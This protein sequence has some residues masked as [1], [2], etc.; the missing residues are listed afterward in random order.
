MT[1]PINRE[2]NLWC[3]INRSNNPGFLHIC[4]PV[5]PPKIPPGSAHGGNYEESIISKIV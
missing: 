1:R 3:C 4:Q 2:I 5:Y